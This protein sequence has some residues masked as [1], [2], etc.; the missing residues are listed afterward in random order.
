ATLMDNYGTPGLALTHG[1][2]AV[3]VDADGREYLDLLGG[4][5]EGRI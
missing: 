2:G 5:A 4:I 3:V 1:A